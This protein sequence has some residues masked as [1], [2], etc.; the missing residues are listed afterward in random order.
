MYTFLIKK[1]IFILIRIKFMEQAIILGRLALSAPRDI[2]KKIKGVSGVTDANLI[3]GPYDFY[4]IL[5]VKTREML[6]DAVL[7]IRSI[8]GVSETMTCYV[9]TFSDIRPEARGANVE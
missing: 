1:F 5:N 8:A 4:I 6:G 9:I 7:Q 3:L 2:V